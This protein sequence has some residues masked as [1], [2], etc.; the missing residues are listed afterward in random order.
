L[1]VAFH[2]GTFHLGGDENTTGIDPR[3]EGYPAGQAVGAITSIIP[4][5]EI[6]RS[7]V[8]EAQRVIDGL[9]VL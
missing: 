6:V 7:I 8:D 1:A 4:A 3:R 5:G 2:D 9:G